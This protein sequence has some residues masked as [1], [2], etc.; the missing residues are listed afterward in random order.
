MTNSAK[1]L[2]PSINAI[3]KNDDAVLLHLSINADLMCFQGHFEEAP[4]APGI[5]QLDWAVKFARQYLSMQGAVQEVSVLKFQKLL[6]PEMQVQLEIIKK[7]AN[8]FTFNYRDGKESFS[9]A[10]VELA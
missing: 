6:L 2:L 8:K 7:S 3:E 10:R 9:S 5:A 4:I 1:R